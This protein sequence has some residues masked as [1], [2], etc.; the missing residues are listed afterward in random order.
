MQRAELAIRVP[1]FGGH[2]LELGDFG[3]V[4]RGCAWRTSLRFP[5]GGQSLRAL[6]RTIMDH[7]SGQKRAVDYLYPPVEPFDQRM[8]DMG[9]GHRH[10]CRAMRQP[11]GVPVLVLH[12]GPGGGCS[13]AMRRYFDPAVYRV[14]LF[15]QRGCGR[16]RP[17]PRLQTTPPGIWSPI[18]RRSARPWDRAV[19]PVRRLLGGDAGADLR[20]HPSRPGAPSG[21]ARRLPDDAG[22]AGLVLRRRRGGVLSRPVGA[23]RRP[24]SPRRA[25]R[26][27][28]RLSPAAVFRRT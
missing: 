26:S 12:G 19:H 18:S 27:D 8:L 21:P 22:R 23:L 13:P 7:R 15:D 24:D 16:S 20:D 25:R 3:G 5:S 14:V 4:D 11:D 2:R 1:P 17:M 28:R 10:L 6:Y 9:D